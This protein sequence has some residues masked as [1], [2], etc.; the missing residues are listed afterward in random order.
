MEPQAMYSVYYDRKLVA[1]VVD[2]DAY[3]GGI[4]DFCHYLSP[5]EGLA[6]AVP[7]AGVKHRLHEE[8]DEGQSDE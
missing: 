6:H 5:N 4:M 7:I 2:S 8:N 1:I 3:P